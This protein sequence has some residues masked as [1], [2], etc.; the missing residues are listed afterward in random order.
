MGLSIYPP[1]DERLWTL[2]AVVVP[3]G[4]DEAKVRARLL[5]EYNLE[6]GGGLGVLAGKVWRVGL[7]GHTSTRRNVMLFLAALED[8]LYSEGVGIEQGAAGCAASGIYS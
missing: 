8:I 2:N 7:M 1:E 5:R 3:D 6:I 4:V